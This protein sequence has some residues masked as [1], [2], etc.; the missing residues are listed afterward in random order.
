LCVDGA[1]NVLTCLL[2]HSFHA[3]VQVYSERALCYGSTSFKH[4]PL[5]GSKIFV[6]TF[7]RL[8]LSLSSGNRKGYPLCRA[9]YI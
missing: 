5:F 3:P 9:H 2:I 1:Y 8:F 6:C 7:F 4:W